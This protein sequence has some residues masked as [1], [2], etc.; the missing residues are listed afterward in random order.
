MVALNQVPEWENRALYGK[1]PGLVT[2]HERHAM[3]SMR[4]V[5]ITADT[6]A[7]AHHRFFPDSPTHSASDEQ[8]QCANHRHRMCHRDESDGCVIS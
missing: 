5:Y 6:Y 2:H 1:S 8:Q 7:T 3:E 4:N